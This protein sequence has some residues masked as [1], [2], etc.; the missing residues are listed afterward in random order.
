MQLMS[1][2]KKKKPLLLHANNIIDINWCIKNGRGG[3]GTHAGGIIVLSGQ[4]CVI[5]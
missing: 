4:Q 3:G 1:F 5:N 2:A